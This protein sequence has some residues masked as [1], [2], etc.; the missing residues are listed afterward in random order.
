MLVGLVGLIIILCYLRKIA[1]KVSTGIVTQELYAKPERFE[2]K[3][4]ED[5]EYPYSINLVMTGKVN[6]TGILCIERTDS[7]CYQIDTI[8]NNFN[9]KYQGDWYSDNCTIKYEP[10]TSTKGELTIDY[11][12]YA[13]RRK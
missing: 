10:I 8:S 11:N 1:G 3:I 6:G 2:I 9:V 13:A 5:C 7:T 12:I 4:D